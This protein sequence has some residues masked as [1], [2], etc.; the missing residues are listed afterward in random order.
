MPRTK[1]IYWS[2]DAI[3]MLMKLYKEQPHLYDAKH[4]QYFNKDCRAE[5]FQQ[6]VLEMR[7]IYDCI[8]TTDVKTKICTLRS[9]YLSYLKKEK[10]YIKNGMEKPN[11]VQCLEFLRPFLKPPEMKESVDLDIKPEADSDVPNCLSNDESE[12]GSSFDPLWTSPNDKLDMTRPKKII[13]SPEAIKMLIELYEKRPNLYDPKHAQYRNKQ[14]RAKALRQIVKGMRKIYDNIDTTDIKNK[15]GTLRSQYL[16]HLKNEA[17]YHKSGLETHERMAPFCVKYIEFLKPHLRFSESQRAS[18][19][20][21]NHTEIKPE[22]DIEPASCLEIHETEIKP[23]TVCQV[24]EELPNSL[25]DDENESDSSL[26]SNDTLNTK[27]PKKIRW[28][29]EAIRVLITLYENRPN[30]YDPQHTDYRSKQARAKSLQQIVKELR[31]IY[32]TI[33]TEDIRNKFSTLRSQYLSHL[34]MEANYSNTRDKI[35]PFWVQYIRFLKPFLKCSNEQ[36]DEIKSETS[37]FGCSSFLNDYESDTNSSYN[38]LLSCSPH[39]VLDIIQAKDIRW[40]P[41]G[42]RRLIKLYEQCPNL[43]DPNNNQYRNK[44]L[45]ANSFQQIVKEMRKIYDRIDIADINSKIVALRSQYLC[46]LKQK[47]IMPNNSTPFWVPYMTFLKPFLKLTLDSDLNH[48]TQAETDTEVPC[49]L[50]DSQSASMPSIDPL[51]D[52]LDDGPTS[53]KRKFKADVEAFGELIKAEMEQIEN[54]SK[55]R[56]LRM[57]LMKIIAAEGED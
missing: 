9:Q 41:E 8:L 50:S 33:D 13:W 1:K 47:E 4:E 42:I 57:K 11:W 55:R 46:Y 23:E 25:R 35:V 15:I 32:D 51:L 37:D 54:P 14:F 7:K 36:T 38:P 26:E 12:A 45:R 19:S 5:S 6:I 40:G 30:L 28:H 43:Y 16:V 21:S 27:K 34:K 10:N 29:P 52:S 44:V 17:N 2:P 56:A 48:Q 24:E 31:K 39:N 22:A 18:E 20:D 53:N 49:Y 3:K